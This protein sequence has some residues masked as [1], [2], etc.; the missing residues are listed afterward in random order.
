MSNVEAQT[1]QQ[2][3]ANEGMGPIH[4]LENKC[5][6]PWLAAS[7]ESMDGRAET[8][9]DGQVCLTIDGTLMA[10][11]SANRI[12]WDGKLESLPTWDEVAGEPTD[13]SKTYQPNG[14]SLVLMS[15]NVD[16]AA[17]GLQLP[18]LLIAKLLGYASIQGIEHVIG[19]FRP[20]AY[21]KAVLAAVNEGGKLPPFETYCSSTD[22]HGNYIDPWLRALARN[23]MTPIAIDSKAMQVSL[24]AEEFE[25]VKQHSWQQIELDGVTIWCPDETGVFYQ[26]PDGSYLYKEINLWGK[27]V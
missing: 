16:P 15:M 5:W 23:G 1:W 22:D 25:G 18:K 20:S 7:P 24:S 13:Y 17:R 6:A 11:L 8:F 19:S 9:P 12:N 3:A 21:G 14:N 10:T 2:F 26:R 27:L 4:A